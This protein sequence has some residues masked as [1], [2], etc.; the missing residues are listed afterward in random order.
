M[1]QQTYKCSNSTAGNCQNNPP[2]GSEFWTTLVVKAL[3]PAD[4][5]TVYGGWLSSYR[6][7]KGYLVG[8]ATS[9]AVYEC[10]TETFCQFHPTED[11]NGALGWSNTFFRVPTVTPNPPV[12]YYDASTPHQWLTGDKV[13]YNSVYY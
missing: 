5:A 3:N 6:Y 12:I 7:R 4:M 9:D 10:T 13:I 8:F 11:S 1:D 2:A